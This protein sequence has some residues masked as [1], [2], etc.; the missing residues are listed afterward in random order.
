MNKILC[1]FRSTSLDKPSAPLPPLD[2]RAMPAFESALRSA[3][4]ASDRSL[5]RVRPTTA[6]SLKGKSAASKCAASSPGS[7]VRGRCVGVPRQALLDSLSAREVSSS[8]NGELAL[9]GHQFQ[10]ALYD[11][12][13]SRC[14]FAPLV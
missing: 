10:A 5:V 11:S 4:A 13:A 7:S 14:P 2:V 12:D 9:A 6:H 8:D 3:M 1:C